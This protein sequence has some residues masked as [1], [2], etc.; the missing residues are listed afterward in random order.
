MNDDASS[1]VIDFIDYLPPRGKKGNWV[2][3]RQRATSSS[4]RRFD[5][6]G[7]GGTQQLV[8]SFER[9]VCVCVQLHNSDGTLL[10]LLWTNPF[11]VCWMIDDEC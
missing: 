10:L 4:S 2:G 9:C 1:D 3:K 7:G 5:D 11:F 8:Q 6:G